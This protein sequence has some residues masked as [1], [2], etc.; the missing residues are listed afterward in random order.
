M[1]SFTLS[2]GE[3]VIV[4]DDDLE[5][6]LAVGPWYR[7]R[8]VV[9]R[10]GRPK[11][12]T[13][14]VRTGRFSEPKLYLHRHLMGLNKGNPLTVDHLNG[15]GLDNRKSN[16]EVVTQAENSRRGRERRAMEAVVA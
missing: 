7:T 1:A 6:V 12:A 10:G 5:R 13:T 2:T 4:D 9:D 14:Y 11:T 3:T 15:D 8:P 16:L